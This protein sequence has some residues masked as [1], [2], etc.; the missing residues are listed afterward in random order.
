[1]IAAVMQAI[2]VRA[3]VLHV[4]EV[5]GYLFT[6][7]RHKT[8]GWPIRDRV[9]S[10]SYQVCLECGRKRLFD[11]QKFLA[12][13]GFANDLAD[14]LER[15]ATRWETALSKDFSLPAQNVGTLVDDAPCGAAV[16]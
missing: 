15:N 12:Y 16:T 2:K 9:L 1:V 5:V 13:G 3:A 7:C 10:C 14:L 6:S 8:L 4:N 11:E